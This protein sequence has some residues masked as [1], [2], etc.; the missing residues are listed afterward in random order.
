MSQKNDHI[1]LGNLQ[2]IVDGFSKFKDLYIKH[3]TFNDE[4]LLREYYD[5]QLKTLTELPLAEDQVQLLMDKGIWPKE[6]EGELNLY[7]D[8]AGRCCQPKLP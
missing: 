6:K 3:F 8:Y 4:I 1:L 5:S 2:Q 7:G